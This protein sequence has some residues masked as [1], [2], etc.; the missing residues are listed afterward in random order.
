MR[1]QI[2]A[3]NAPCAYDFQPQQSM[4]FGEDFA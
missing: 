2:E 1:E 4:I 3:V